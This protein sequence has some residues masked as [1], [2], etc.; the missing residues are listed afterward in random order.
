MSDES[1]TESDFDSPWKEAIDGYFQ[2]FLRLFF[3]EAHRDIDWSR[4]YEV[5]DKELQKIAPDAERGKLEV[6]V[7]IKVWTLAGEDRWVLIHI[8]V[9]S[10]SRSDFPRRM[11]LYHVRI[12]DLYGRPVASIA[13]LAD[14]SPGCRPQKYAYDLW[15]CG[16]DFRFPTVKLLDLGADEER[17]AKSDNPFAVVVLA[18]LKAQQTKDNHARRRVWKLRLVRGLYNRGWSREEVWKL[19]RLIDWFLQLPK[20]V[21]RQYQEELAAIESE[22]K[23][24]YVTSIERFAME[25]GEA[26]GEVRGEAKGLR[27]GISVLLRVKFGPAGRE[28][29]PQLEAIAD[30]TRLRELSTAI[31][32]AATVDEVRHLLEV[33]HEPA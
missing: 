13:V 3:P 26:R 15:G 4:G 30:P 25:E 18:H 19:I 2:P 8:E 1:A 23:M 9:Q 31:E 17:L 7:L 33:P 10:Q 11:F 27:E 16:M 12:G 21:E 14:E 24:P 5:L 32:S 20:P 28:L 29:M 22:N 6:D